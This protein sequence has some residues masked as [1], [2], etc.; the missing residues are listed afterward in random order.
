MVDEGRGREIRRQGR[1]G[2]VELE[3]EGRMEGR[4]E[5]KEGGKE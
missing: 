2:C 1:E 4:M 3:R 5:G